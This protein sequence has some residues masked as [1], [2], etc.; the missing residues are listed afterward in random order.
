M[1]T[2]KDG[3][4]RARNFRRLAS[5]SLEELPANNQAPNRRG[6]TGKARANNSFYNIGF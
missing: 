4:S 3:R 2:D 1:D 5:G 6:A